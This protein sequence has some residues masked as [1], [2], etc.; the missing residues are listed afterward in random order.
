MSHTM[1]C[2]PFLSG[3]CL[4]IAVMSAVCFAVEPTVPHNS[5]LRKIYVHFR[6]ITLMMFSLSVVMNSA[7]ITNYS[8]S[9][10]K[11]S[12]NK[13]PSATFVFVNATRVFIVVRPCDAICGQ[14]FN[15]FERR[16]PSKN[17]I[18]TARPS[19]IHQFTEDHNP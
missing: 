12:N 11:L 17:Y 4:A 9:S 6:T 15:G 1:L 5:P 2:A 7:C 19:R 16:T 3:N 13:V 10:Q 18:P 8:F 14:C